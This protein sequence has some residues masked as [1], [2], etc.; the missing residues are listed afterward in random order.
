M[1]P[2]TEAMRAR[3]KKFSLDVL[4]FLRTLP[5]TDEC[6]DISGQLRR[7]GNG[8][9]SNYRSSCRARS[10]SEFISRINVTL[11]EADESAFWL[12]VIVDSDIATNQE[13]RRLLDEANQLSAIFAASSLTAIEAEKRGDPDPRG[14]PRR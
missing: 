7:S 5:M 9:G 3:T 12:E 14:R 6:R 13:S 2:E 8:V 4:R 10:R 1:N 11:D